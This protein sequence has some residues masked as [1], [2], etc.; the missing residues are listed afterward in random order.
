MVTVNDGL[1]SSGFLSLR[2]LVGE[3]DSPSLSCGRV[4]AGQSGCLSVTA[5]HTEDL[6]RISFTCRAAIGK[7]RRDIQRL[8]ADS[9]Q[10]PQEVR[11]QLHSE[12]LFI[13]KIHY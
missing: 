8:Q 10:E 1:L 4:A 7:E 11:D 2:P 13:H 12:S 6:A 3:L 9:F 5:L